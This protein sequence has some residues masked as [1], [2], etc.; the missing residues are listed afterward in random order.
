MVEHYQGES[1]EG[2]ELPDGMA[3]EAE[4]PSEN[5]EGTAEESSEGEEEASD[6]SDEEKPKS[7]FGRL[8]EAT[9]Y[10]VMIWLSFFIVLTGILLMLLEWLSYDMIV[11]P[12]Y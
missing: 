6:D 9:P 3:A 11:Y 5:A 8:A 1:D 4:E 2:D 7:F 10:E 12:K